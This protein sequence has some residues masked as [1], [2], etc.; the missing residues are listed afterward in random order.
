MGLHGKSDGWKIAG[1]GIREDAERG[2]EEEEAGLLFF[3]YGANRQDWVVAAVFNGA[4]A[5]IKG[6]SC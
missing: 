5:P 4:A 2:K 3:F 6:F 1:R